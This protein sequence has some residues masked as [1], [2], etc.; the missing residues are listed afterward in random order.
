MIE[1]PGPPISYR[2]RHIREDVAL[3]D[4]ARQPHPEVPRQII[5]REFVDCDI[6]GPLVVH[7]GQGFLLAALAEFEAEQEEA[8][9]PLAAGDT[10]PDDVVLLDDCRM[11]G[12]RFHE[13]VFTGAVSE[14]NLL[15]RNATFAGQRFRQV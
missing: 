9:R 10:L 13:V 4:L 5:N 11:T 3:P 7:T 15:F 12:C 1:P 8:L 2:H 6:R 14:I